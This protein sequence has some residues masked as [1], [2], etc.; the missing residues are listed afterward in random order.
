MADTSSKTLVLWNWRSTD[1]G[2]KQ[3]QQYLNIKLEAKYSKQ[4]KCSQICT[5]FSYTK[6]D[7]A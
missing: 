5:L 1:W 6:M 2:F 7:L 3:K 4:K